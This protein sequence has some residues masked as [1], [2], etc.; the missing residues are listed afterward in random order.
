MVRR[1]NADASGSICQ[2]PFADRRERAERPTA[3]LPGGDYVMV[4]DSATL[5]L[6]SCSRCNGKMYAGYHDQ[7]RLEFSCLT[8][9]EYLFIDAPRKRGAEWQGPRHETLAGARVT[10]AASPSAGGSAGGSCRRGSSA[11]SAHAP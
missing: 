4:V 9:G 6:K 8:C 2:P 10:K 1:W 7:F 3:R 5:A 11:R